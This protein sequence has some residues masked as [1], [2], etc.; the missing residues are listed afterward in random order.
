MASDIVNKFLSE[1][2]E[3]S[4]DK[5]IE[6][7]VTDQGAEEIL[8][9]LRELQRM[10]NMGCSR[11]LKIED[12]GHEGDKDAKQSKFGWDGDGDAKIVT[13]KVDGKKVE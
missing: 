5:T 13:L 7:V 4:T 3:K 9:L 10:G 1:R 8:P 12:W 11:S 6:L 2:K